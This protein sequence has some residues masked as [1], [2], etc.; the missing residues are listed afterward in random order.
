MADA[1]PSVGGIPLVFGGNVFGWTLDRDKSFAVLDA[2]A[3]AGGTM[4]DTADAYSV[5][6]PG[7]E[8]GESESTIG[9]WLKRSGRRNTKPHN[10]RKCIHVRRTLSRP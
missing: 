9:E 2:F 5:W 7:H 1:H 8:G 4:I 3:A 6:V 10:R